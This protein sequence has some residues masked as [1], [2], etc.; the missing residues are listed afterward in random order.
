M[1]LRDDDELIEGLQLSAEEAGEYLWEMPMY[2]EYFEDL[3][4]RQRID[5]YY[6]V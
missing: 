6:K 2:E 3:V 1:T 5:E 4:R